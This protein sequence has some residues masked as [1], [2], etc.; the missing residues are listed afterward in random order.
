LPLSWRFVT[1]SEVAVLRLGVD[2]RASVLDDVSEPPNVIVQWT[3][4]DLVAA[5]LSGRSNLET[6]PDPPRIRFATASGRK[7]WSLVGTSLGL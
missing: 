7:A 5:L 6:R 4:V 2:G 3:Q 1:E